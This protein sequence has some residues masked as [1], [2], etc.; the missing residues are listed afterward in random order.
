MTGAEDLDGGQRIINGRVDI[1]AYEYGSVNIPFI[2]INTNIIDFGGTIILSE[3]V[4]TVT[5][6]N[7]GAGTLSGEVTNVSVP[8]S[9]TSGIPYSLEES[10]ETLVIFSFSPTENGIFSNT[11]VFTGGGDVTALLIGTG[12]PEPFLFIILL[13]PP[14]LKG[15]RGI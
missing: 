9:V 8:F 3:N 15:V 13:I 2:F 11:V 1:G 7:V 6:Q 12:I 10:E 14:F 4:Q 5:V